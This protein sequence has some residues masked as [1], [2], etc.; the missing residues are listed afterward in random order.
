MLITIVNLVYNK[1][2]PCYSRRS[3]NIKAI[4]SSSKR[5]KNVVNKIIRKL[6]YLLKFPFC[7]AIT[8]KLLSYMLRGFFNYLEIFRRL[9]LDFSCKS[10]IVLKSNAFCNQLQLDRQSFS[11]CLE[12]RK[13]LPLLLMCFQRK[14]L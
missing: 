2:K 9:K 3:L 13:V 6:K 7:F 12:R 10:L 11:T 14:L 1:F 4:Y 5:I 8:E